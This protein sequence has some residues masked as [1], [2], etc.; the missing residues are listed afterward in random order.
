MLSFQAKPIDQLLR[1][2]LSAVLNN[3]FLKFDLISRLLV[4]M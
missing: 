1:H 4:Y 3:S 2:Y